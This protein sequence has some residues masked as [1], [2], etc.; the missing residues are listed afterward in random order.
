MFNSNRFFKRP[1]VLLVIFFLVVFSVFYTSK[2]SSQ[3]DVYVPIK[4]KGESK[5]KQALGSKINGKPNEQKKSSSNEEKLSQQN[6]SNNNQK[7]KATTEEPA[8]ISLAPFMPKMENEELKAELGRS[9]WKLLHNVLARYPDK[10]SEEEKAT[11][12]HFFRYFVK[13][14]PCGDCAQHF[15]KLLELYPPQVESKQNAALWGCHIHNKVNERLGKKIYDCTNILNDY[16]CG[17]GDDA[18][19]LFSLDDLDDDDEFIEDTSSVTIKKSEENKDANTKE[20]VKK[21]AAAGKLEHINN[22]EDKGL[23]DGDIL[24]HLNSIMIESK[25]P[26]QKGG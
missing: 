15:Q 25:E 2:S 8:E 11:L 26:L 13:V 20:N 19:P 1:V 16:D 24:D 14:Y 6:D 10:P 9:T 7:E 22:A 3:L 4:T 12:R 23:E 17:C 21:A 18:N 5:S